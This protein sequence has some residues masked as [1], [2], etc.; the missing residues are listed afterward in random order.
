MSRW[1]IAT[2]RAAWVAAVF[3][4][5]TLGLLG[6][7][8]LI[9]R[10]SDPNP[11]TRIDELVT[12]L[13]LDPNNG[14]LLKELRHQDEWLRVSYFRSVRFAQDGFYLLLIG[15]AVFLVLAKSA[16]KLAAKPQLPD[17]SA[18]ARNEAD[19]LTSQR[20]VLALGMSLAGI[21]ALIA[22]LS[23][24]DSVAAYVDGKPLPQITPL[25]PASPEGLAPALGKAPATVPP[26]VI[27]SP[28]AVPPEPSPL[29]GTSLAPL[30]LSPAPSK[31]AAVAPKKSIP[32]PSSGWPCFRGPAAG[33]ASA[34]KAPP[35]WDAT[36]GKGVLWK[37]DLGLP[38][39]NSPIISGGRVFLSG[40]DATHREICAFDL[41]SG[42]NLWRFAVSAAGA[43]VKS[44]S[45]AGYAPS[46]MAAGNGRVF[47][48]FVDGTVACV[49]VDGKPQWSR[50]FGPL[51]NNYGFASSLLFAAGELIVQ[52]DQGS[53]PDALKSRLYAL[54]PVS[55]K[56]VWEAKRKVSA[57]WSS[58]IAA[59]VN[60]SLAII[61]LAEP[62]IAAYDANTGLELW[63]ADGLS[64]EIATSPAFGGGKLFA[65]QQGSYLMSVSASDG[66]VAWKTS[67]PALPDIGSPVYGAGLVFLSTSDGT[68]SAVDAATGK[69]A[70][71]K[72]L[73]KP[74]RSSP[75]VVGDEVLLVGLDGVLREFEANR[76]FKPLATHKFGEAVEATPAFEG[77]RMVVR[78]EHHLFC[79]GGRQ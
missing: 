27:A 31:S 41:E 72:R 76:T 3:C 57:S 58:P 50:Q 68:L 11:P 12:R 24:H 78:G 5:I 18:P 55:G 14:N 33:A 6:A 35:D 17:P 51:E 13:N 60:G 39:W 48:A 54:D 56:T 63:N 73:E 7:N 30:P 42:K 29:G 25:A 22:T 75:V 59:P 34:W 70:W 65:A 36:T 21:L 26:A 2:R 64:G 38:G 71:E 8:A 45:D 1:A 44:S 52:V 23:R 16:E 66:K 19:A 74:A 20:T 37:V 9:S 77:K 46:T 40:A 15:V 28:T 69:I 49:T 47:A 62:G 32:V 4:I 53:S 79:I 43:Q 67:D 10:A 61:V